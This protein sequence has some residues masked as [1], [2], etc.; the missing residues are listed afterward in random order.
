[1]KLNLNKIKLDN[2]IVIGVS[3]GPDSMCL[4]NLLKEQTNKIIVCHI[5]H[6]VRKESIDEENF[7]RQYCEENNLIFETMLIEEYT[8]RNFENEARKKRYLFYEEVLNKYNAKYL[9]LAHHGDDLIETVLMKIVR[10]S[11][12]EGYAGIKTISHFKNFIIVRPLLEYT[13]EEIIKYN[14]SHNIPYFIDS[15][16]T[17]TEYTRNRYRKN[18]LPILKEEEKN[19]HK[20]FIK[21]SKTLEEYDVY[22]KK[23]VEKNINNIFKNN[24]I[25][26]NELKKLD[27]FLQKNTLYYILNIIYNNESNIITEKHINNIIKLISN[28]I[29]NLSLDMPQNKILIKEYDKIYIKKKNKII[30][31]PEYKIKFDD[32]IIIE[33]LEFSIIDVE[34]NDG[35]NICRLNKKDIN[36]PLYFRNRKN[37][38]YII[39]KGSNNKK[40]IKEIFIEE[41]I[42]TR[43]RNTYPLLVDSSD[44]IIWIPNIKK[45][46]F[47]IKKDENNK[48]YDIIIKCNEREENYD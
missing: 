10:G 16:N 17:N 12:I 22:I 18:I 6:N 34:E 20:K 1:M 13:K 3:S 15:S 25:Y 2:Y 24:T 39:L 36:P 46:A 32:N 29:P 8:E 33:N 14:K 31:N 47:C 28:K 9:F 48:N 30:K 27:Q 4:L 45:S 19:I 37:G 41:K 35:N 44:N 42:P 5:N 43:I 26:I 40:K 7:L 21:Y 38:D 23:L 11:N